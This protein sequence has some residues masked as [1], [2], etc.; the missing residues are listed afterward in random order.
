MSWAGHSTPAPRDKLATAA[1]TPL[2]S[3]CTVW[4][5]LHE[6]CYLLLHVVRDVRHLL[7]LPYVVR[8]YGH[9]RLHEE[10]SNKL[11]VSALQC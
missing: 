5:T 10:T 4:C 3:L 11:H 7:L 1:T 8:D 9:L 2:M 6:V